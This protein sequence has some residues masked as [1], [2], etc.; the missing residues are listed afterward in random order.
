MAKLDQLIPNHV[1][2]VFQRLNLNEM[3]LNA[4][5]NEHLRRD[6]QE[7]DIYLENI[8]HHFLLKQRI[9]QI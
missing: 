3:L 1:Y 7:C 9:D 2:K 6:R 8:L 4:C 5:S